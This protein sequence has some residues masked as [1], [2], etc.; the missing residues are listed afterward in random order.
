MREP[1]VK[2]TET[3]KPP[4]LAVLSLALIAISP[5]PL[6]AS[7]PC[8]TNLFPFVSITKPTNGQTFTWASTVRI[9]ATASDPDG[10]IARVEFFADTNYLGSATNAPYTNNW[11]GV[12]SEFHW[13]PYLLTA[14]AIDNCGAIS[15]S[16]PVAIYVI[17]DIYRPFVSFAIPSDGAL[18]RP[19]ATIQLLAS[20]LTSDG[21]ENPVSFFADA[22]LLGVVPEPPY[23]LVASNLP[24]GSYVITATYSDDFMQPSTCRPVTVTVADLKLESPRLDLGGHFRFSVSG[25]VTGSPLV[26]L[27]SSNLFTWDSI[28]TN[29]PATPLLELDVGPP[30]NPPQRFFRVVSEK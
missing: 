20:V 23:S 29:V 22:T 24:A 11:P 17:Q 2:Y 30:A 26:L 9:R 10:S 7:D 27:A 13:I 12:Y 28:E 18:F 21:S 14:R 8:S 5:S 3:S 25:V 1:S 15:T 19:P 6:H 4:A 16:A